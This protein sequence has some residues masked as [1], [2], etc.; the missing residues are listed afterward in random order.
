VAHT[1]SSHRSRLQVCVLVPPV[2]A[3]KANPLQGG[4]A[5]PMDLSKRTQRES[6]AAGLPNSG[7]AITSPG[8]RVAPPSTTGKEWGIPTRK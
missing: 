8:E 4:G 1:S 5:K 6:E 2:A 7:G 3:R